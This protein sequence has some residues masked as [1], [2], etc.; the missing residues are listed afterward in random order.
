MKIYLIA[1]KEYAVIG[2]D[3]Y[4]KLPELTITIAAT[5]QPASATAAPIRKP[6]RQSAQKRKYV[7]KKGYKRGACGRCGKEGHSAWHCP[8]RPQTKGAKIQAKKN[9]ATKNK[10]EHI[11][12]HAS[13]QE[14]PEPRPSG[15][16]VGT[17]D[18]LKARVDEIR[19][20]NPGITLL[21]IAQQLGN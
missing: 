3:L 11:L 1:G 15:K 14:Q 9:A 13:E 2:T 10:V 19:K 18:E 21:V 4:E 8:D 6:N 17:I 20:K 5:D 7:P 12:G 16:F